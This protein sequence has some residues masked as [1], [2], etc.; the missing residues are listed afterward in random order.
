MFSFV[1]VKPF[2]E[3]ENGKRYLYVDGQNLI[4]GL[5]KLNS[6]TLYFSPVD[7]NQSSCQISYPIFV[8]SEFSKPI[9]FSIAKNQ[10]EQCYSEGIYLNHYFSKIHKLVK[11]GD[12]TLIY[13]SMYSLGGGFE[14]PEELKF[15]NEDRDK[16]Y[17]HFT[18]SKRDF[19]FTDVCISLQ[20]G[21]LM[22]KKNKIGLKKL[23]L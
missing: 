13:L 22:V 20:H 21:L 14:S 6:D 3:N 18:N 1:H 16:L 7:E 8:L 10:D 19:S 12:D 4:D 11:Y 2:V 17:V 23:P 5:W 15:S 9:L